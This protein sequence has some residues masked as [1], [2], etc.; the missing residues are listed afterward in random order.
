MCI[1]IFHVKERDYKEDL[2]REIERCLEF[3]R[4]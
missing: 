3:L 2:Q 4:S 1:Q